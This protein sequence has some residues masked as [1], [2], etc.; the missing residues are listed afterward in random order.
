MI[1]ATPGRLETPTA[2]TSSKTTYSCK[3][4][5][6]VSFLSCSFAHFARSYTSARCVTS[7]RLCLSKIR[8]IDGWE[9]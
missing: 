9:P 1:R 4:L 2:E 8:S 6:N 7:P 5:L 3:P